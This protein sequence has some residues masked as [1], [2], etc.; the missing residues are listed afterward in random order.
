MNQY[1]NKCHLGK[2]LDVLRTM[3]DCCVDAVV[4]DPPYGLSDQDPDQVRLCLE[5]WLAG[6]Q[7]QPRSPLDGKPYIRKGFMGKDWDDWVPGPEVWRECIRVLK[8][9]GYLLAFAG[10][11]TQHLM[12]LGLQLAG[13]EIRDMLAWV[14]GSGFP[15]SH[16]GD[17]GGT[18]LKPALEPITMARKPLIGTVAANWAVH[19]TGALNI[20][21]C[22]I[23]G[24][25]MQP[26]TGAGGLPRRSVDEQRG[27]GVVAQPHESGRWPANLIH[28][29]SDEVLSNFPITTSGTGAIKR[30][31]S[32]DRSGNTGAA[33]GAESRPDGAEMISY[34][35]TGNAARFFYCAK[36][37]SDE[38]N[39]GLEGRLTS[40]GREVPA[41]NAYQ[42]GKTVRKNH[43]PTVKPGDLM[44]YLCRLVT[45]AGGIVLDPYIGSG[46]TC[47]AALLEGFQFIGI[48]REAE[49]I[50]IARARIASAMR[51]GFQPSLLEAA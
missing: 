46:T 16:N 34:G 4:T 10:T 41:D 11:R 35:D 14:Y 31:S 42:R 38:R 44:R 47:C 29:G 37:S 48:E 45:P 1:L 23:A 7:Y 22:R 28:D 49:Y 25:P 6:R 39:E 15:K 24:E 17:W 19:G 2:C 30:A 27:P 43:H 40:D 8:P 13:F 5:D 18:A 3:P 50:E 36:A 33:F 51:Q 9:G 12:G 32:T 21:A 26:N 20:D